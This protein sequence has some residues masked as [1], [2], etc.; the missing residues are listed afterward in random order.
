[1]AFDDEKLNNKLRNTNERI[2]VLYI[3]LSLIMIVSV[4][5]ELKFYRF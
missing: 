2:V 1:M 4:L 5:M 3:V